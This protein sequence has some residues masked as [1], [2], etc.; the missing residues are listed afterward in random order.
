MN[1]LIHG[2]THN[3]RTIAR[4]ITYREKPKMHIL[5]TQFILMCQQRQDAFAMQ[6]NATTLIGVKS[7]DT[8]LNHNQIACICPNQNLYL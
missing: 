7:N 5:A 8:D 6:C 4:A 2:W 3:Y 1:F